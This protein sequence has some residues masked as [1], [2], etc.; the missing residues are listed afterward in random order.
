MILL[1]IILL[2]LILVYIVRISNNND[3]VKNNSKSEEDQ[4]FVNK[5]KK[6]QHMTKI[7]ILLF[8]V[9]IV[10]FIGLIVSDFTNIDY[11]IADYLAT[12]F[13]EEKELNRLFYFI[14]A[15][16]IV[17]NLIY[18]QVNIGDKLLAYFKT[19]E[20][21]LEINIDKEKIL[22]LLYKKKPAKE[23]DNS[24]EIQEDTKKE[25]KLDWY[26]KSRQFKKDDLKT[27]FSFILN[28]GFII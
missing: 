26:N 15:F 9:G 21:E 27:W 5:T 10:L 23:E 25:E 14:P 8:I 2:L 4:I 1:F 24:N 11:L 13:V 12:D 3:I 17:G 7:S 28:W 18:T 22:S 16:I 20:E 6:E 19:K